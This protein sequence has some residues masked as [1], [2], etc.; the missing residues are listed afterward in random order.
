M[1]RNLNEELTRYKNLMNVTESTKMV[2]LSTVNYPNVKID[3]DGTQNDYVNAAL[4]DDL[5][6]A[7]ES[8]GITLTIT[9]AKTGHK[10][11]T[12]TGNVSRHMSG[13]GVDI[14]ILNGIGSGGATQSYLGNKEFRK[15][16]DKLKDALVSLGYRHTGEGGSGSGESRRSHS[17]DVLWKTLI[18]GNHYNHLHVSNIGDEPASGFLGS[19][20]SSTGEDEN[21]LLSKIL[22]SDFNGK[23]IIDWL[24]GAGDDFWEL[25]KK[26]T[27]LLN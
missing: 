13:E 2:K 1:K 21:E 12:T 22:D 27:N 15:L 17:K 14:S 9:T 5:Q 10:E 8:A 11:M 25:L 26:F 7:A 4:L 16:G 3:N 6:K 18:G 20:T 19:Q 23:K 24:G